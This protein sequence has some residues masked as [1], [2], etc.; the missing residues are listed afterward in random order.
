MKDLNIEEGIDLWDLINTGSA[1]I[2]IK[3]GEDVLKVNINRN[4]F[5]LDIYNYYKV[6]TIAWT[7]SNFLKGDR[8][9]DISF[10]FT[11]GEKS[12]MDM[13]NQLEGIA[14]IFHKRGKTV[15]IKYHGNETI[16]I[17]KDAQSLMLDLLGIKHVQI[18]RKIL[19]LK[20]MVI[21]SEIPLKI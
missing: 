19:A 18:T 3:H 8:H 17:G 7:L 11:E 21:F 14:K 16:K 5:V 12:Y 20:L 15:I 9:K 6:K 1:S 4:T 10:K 13:L 2:D